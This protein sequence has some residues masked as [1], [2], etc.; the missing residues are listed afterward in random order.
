MAVNVAFRQRRVP[1]TSSRPHPIRGLGRWFRAQ[2]AA[3]WAYGLALALWASSW[4]LHRSVLLAWLPMEPVWVASL[5]LGACVVHRLG[6][7]LAVRP[8]VLGPLVLVVVCFLPGALQTDPGGYG[9]AKVAQLVFVVLPVV[10][11]AMI[12]L[13]TRDA[14]RAWACAQLVVGAAVA[15]AA[16]TSRHVNALQPGRFTL[17]TVNT[18]GTGR[19]VGVAV[20]VLVLVAATS[21]RRGWWAIPTG[22]LFAGV[23]IQVG[24][25]GPLLFALA[26]CVIVLLAAR[27]FTARRA[28]PVIIAVL[29]AGV[30]YAYAAADGGEGGSRV[31]DSLRKG[32]IDDARSAMLRDAVSAGF[33]HPL[34]VGWGNFLD[35]SDT[36]AR[37]ANDRGVSYAHNVFAEA[38]SE[39]GIPA[40]LGLAILVVLAVC[41]LWSATEQRWDVVVWGTLLYWLLNALVSLDL[42]WN[43]FMWI[44]LACALVT[45]GRTTGAD[46]AH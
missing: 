4:D 26:A 17:A 30:G 16:E 42:V 8:Q 2:R 45:S 38:F 37:I 18:I 19:L 32:L 10:L 7:P 21:L 39:G 43:R 40:L 6:Q 35:Y 20:V 9:P 5:L 46:N 44:A 22:V 12:L 24:S 27:W 1:M 36:A 25:R 28:V 33:S 23:L 15:V 34:G 31:V 41:R 13:D 11:A 3:P 29:V 14:R